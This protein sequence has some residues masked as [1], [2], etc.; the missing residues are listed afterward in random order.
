MFLKLQGEMRTS[1]VLFSREQCDYLVRGEEIS[2]F[3][4]NRYNPPLECVFITNTYVFKVKQYFLSKKASI[5]LGVHSSFLE[6]VKASFV[7]LGEE[8]LSYLFNEYCPNT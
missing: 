6:M 7:R 5:L 4:T 2:L 1:E 3:S 8:S